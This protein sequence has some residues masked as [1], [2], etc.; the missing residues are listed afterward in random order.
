MT[1]PLNFSLNFWFFYWVV[2]VYTIKIASVF[3]NPNWISVPVLLDS[4]FIYESI[5]NWFRAVIFKNSAFFGFVV[6]P[7]KITRQFIKDVELF[8]GYRKLLHIFGFVFGF[9]LEN[10]VVER[11]WVS[12]LD[13]VCGRD[14][15]AF[16]VVGRAREEIAAAGL[17][18]VRN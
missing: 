1:T 3:L 6:S 8:I 5:F 11:G 10:G 4:Q 14:A 9:G 16:F 13:C 7:L 2:P 17:S 12:V 15:Q 18:R